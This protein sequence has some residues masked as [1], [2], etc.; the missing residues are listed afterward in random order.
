[1]FNPRLL[2]DLRDQFWSSLDRELS[3][4]VDRL[5]ALGYQHILELEVQYHPL[6]AEKISD[7]GLDGF[8]PKFS[9][10]GRVTVMETISKRVL[11][12]S[13]GL[14]GSGLDSGDSKGSETT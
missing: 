2:R 9:G 1:M 4:L 5:R 11:Y 8:L 13:D 3:T 6:L 7:A 12:C 14:L 10:K